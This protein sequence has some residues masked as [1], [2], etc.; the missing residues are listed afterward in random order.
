MSPT[1]QQRFQIVDALQKVL[2]PDQ[3]IVQSPVSFQ[4]ISASLQ[5]PLGP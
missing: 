4:L 3:C 2:S 5:L 1:N